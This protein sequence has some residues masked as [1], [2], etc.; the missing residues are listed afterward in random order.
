MLFF[1]N[2]RIF[3]LYLSITAVFLRFEAILGANRTLIFRLYLILFFILFVYQLFNKGV[4]KKALT[5]VLLTTLYSVL[6]TVFWI[7]HLSGGLID[8]IRYILHFLFFISPFYLA[9]FF[10]NSDFKISSID[11][12]SV[13]YWSSI[14]SLSIALLEVYLRLF[15]SSKILALKG[16]Y[17]IDRV[18]SG[19]NA[20]LSADN[21]YSFKYASLMFTDS[22]GLAIILVSLFALMLVFRFR[23]LSLIVC[24]L[25]FFTLSR[26][27]YLG[28]TLTLLIYM[29]FF[30]N[31]FKSNV[32]IS[33]LAVASSFVLVVIYSF[34]DSHTSFHDGSLATK[35][36]I[37][38]SL[39]KLGLVN[40]KE[41]IFGFGIDRGNYIYSPGEN[42]YAHILFALTLGQVGLL[43]TVLYLIL[44]VLLG[45][46][47]SFKL[48]VL[49]FVPF[50]FMGL[51]LASPWEPAPFVYFLVAYYFKLKQEKL[52]D[53]DTLNNYSAL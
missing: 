13:V 33:F 24:V 11:F 26:S 15:H 20:G 28:A 41:L 34:I 2:L 9:Y 10:E 47:Y 12:K 25:I 17:D 31:H 14:T 42:Y 8:V 50:L 16:G 51:S 4:P 23:V 49:F 32:K 37:L 45:Y 7:D 39:S 36:D 19:I 18:E 53:K 35:L 46:Y 5:L 3:I 22:N 38:T 27:A 43:G 48:A 52:Y 40:F 30:G 1:L 29:F 21:F 44:F 6:M